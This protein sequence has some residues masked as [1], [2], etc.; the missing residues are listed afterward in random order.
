MGRYSQ[1]NN[2][3]CKG[4]TRE[5]GWYSQANKL[6]MQMLHDRK[7]VDIIDV[8]NCLCKCYTIENG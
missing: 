4:Y 8:S 6:F 3:L 2:C 7:C 1:A 5:N